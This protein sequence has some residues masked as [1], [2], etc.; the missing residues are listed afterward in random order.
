MFVMLAKQFQRKSA[1]AHRVS[2]P[3]RGLDHVFEMRGYGRARAFFWQKRKKAPKGLFSLATEYFSEL[4]S[5]MFGAGNETR[6]WH[7]TR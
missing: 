2:Y 5:A 1:S 6:I 7:P 3:M 4:C